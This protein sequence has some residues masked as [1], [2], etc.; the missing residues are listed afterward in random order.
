MRA[1][2]HSY[3]YDRLRT[4]PP[5]P[6]APAAAA[7]ARGESLRTTLHTGKKMKPTPEFIPKI[8]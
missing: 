4:L 7:R 3:S 8:P 5:G 6:T 2:V 1:Y